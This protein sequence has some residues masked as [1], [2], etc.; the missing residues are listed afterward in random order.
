[1]IMQTI[2]S[3]FGVDNDDFPPEPP[4]PTATPVG[5]VE[6]QD[7]SPT[8]TLFTNTIHR[9]DLSGKTTTL[10]LKYSCLQRFRILFLN[11]SHST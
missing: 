6:M 4:A 1:M 8:R 11:F 7:H 5:H 10:Y 2:F 9:T 3:Q